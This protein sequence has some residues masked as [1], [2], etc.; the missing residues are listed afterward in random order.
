MYTSNELAGGELSSARL[1]EMGGAHEPL[2]S[3]MQMKTSSSSKGGSH[4]YFV[5]RPV[6][7]WLVCGFRRLGPPP[8]PLLHSPRHSRSRLIS[9]APVRRRHIQ[10][11][12]IRVRTNVKVAYLHCMNSPLRSSCICSGQSLH[13]LYFCFSLH[14][15]GRRAA[16]TRR[17]GGCIR[18]ATRGG[19]MPRSAT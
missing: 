4:G 15:A 18:R 3:H 10:L 11:R 17:G 19:T 1:L 13:C 5:P 9:T 8:R 16:T 6:C 12:L 2:H 7:A 14:N